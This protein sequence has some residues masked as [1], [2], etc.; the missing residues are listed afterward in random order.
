V[1]AIGVMAM[2]IL[3]QL[4]EARRVAVAGPDLIGELRQMGGLSS[5]RCAEIE[6]ACARLR[7]R[8]QPDQLRR[9]VLDE[10]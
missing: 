2:E 4:F 10:K 9:G 3:F 8:E 5:R 1:H 7:R 6:N